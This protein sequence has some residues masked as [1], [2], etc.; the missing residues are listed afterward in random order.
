[1]DPMNGSNKILSLITKYKYVLLVVA[2]G[3]FLLMIPSEEN[4]E[5]SEITAQTNVKRPDI[6]EQL[7]QI[8]SNI[9][10][11]GKV[12]ILLTQLEGPKILYETNED[13]S[14][15]EQ[16]S[17]IRKDIVIITDGNRMESGLVQQIIPPVYLG[18][19]IVCQGGDKASVKLAVVD[20]VSN[21]TGLSSDR[22]SV[23]KM[24]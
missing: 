1:M 14:N 2:A 24:K 22:I 17:S 21:V 11:V 23:L 5:S 15:T 20:A 7:E 19:V 12:K 6:E 16:S 18:A 9:D 13:I 8:L 10:G 3:I 4:L